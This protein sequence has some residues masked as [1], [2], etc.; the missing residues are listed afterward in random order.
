[1]FKLHEDPN[2]HYEA[3]R[4]IGLARYMGGDIGEQLAILP[5]IKPGDF[6]GWYTEWT[7][8]AQRVLSTVDER[9]LSQYHPATLKDVFFRASHYYFVADFFIHGNR[10]DPRMTKN[11]AL[12]RK[13]FDL[14]NSYLHIPGKHALLK[15]TP[16]FDIP[17]ISYRAP[18][19]STSNPRP[20]LIVGGGF[21]SNYEE[22]LHVFG[23]SA[24]ERGYNVILYEGPGQPSLLQGQNVGFI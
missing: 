5:K 3:L 7:K 10:D 9:N 12:W 14:A 20:A 22:C 15:T 13:Y 24:L 21:D 23:V 11:W 2:F 16:G 8:L 4:S 18:Q 17:I 1:M 19:A 6:E